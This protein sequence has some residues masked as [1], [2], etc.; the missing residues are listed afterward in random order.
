[1]SAWE[2]L[3]ARLFLKETTWV[4][5]SKRVCVEVHRFSCS[6]HKSEI[7]LLQFAVFNLFNTSAWKRT[8]TW[9]L[10]LIQATFLVDAASWV[11]PQGLC[12]PPAISATI[13]PQLLSPVWTPSPELPAAGQPQNT[14][15]S[16][17]ST[18]QLP[19]DG[20]NTRDVGLQPPCTPVRVHLHRTMSRPCCVC[21]TPQTPL[22]CSPGPAFLERCH[23]QSS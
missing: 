9:H 19:G 18:L 7:V 2:Y 13:F 23:L 6:T 5:E 10:H 12:Q 3:K 16:C 1:M 17:Y 21:W 22:T 15:C 20:A 4:S 14:P 11:I 8:K